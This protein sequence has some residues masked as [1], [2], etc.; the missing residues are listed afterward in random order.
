MFKGP[1][2][3]RMRCFAVLLAFLLAATLGRSMA[4][5]SDNGN[6]YEAKARLLCSFARYVDWPPK[7]FLRPDSPFVIGVY[8]TDSISETIREYVQSQRIKDRPVQVLHITAKE[9]LPACHILFISRSEAGRY[10]SVLGPVKHENVL[11]VGESD[12]FIDSGGVIEFFYDGVR[13]TYHL[14]DKAATRE[15]LKMKPVIYQLAARAREAIPKN[16]P[17][18]GQQVRM[19]APEMD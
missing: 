13:W 1:H 19:S 15:R 9:Q 7:K 10:K 11:T 14:E 2:Q 12:D 6:E 18:K 3:L 4:G 17:E 8:G 16:I 5:P